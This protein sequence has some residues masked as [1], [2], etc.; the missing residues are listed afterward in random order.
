M[1]DL[2]N[3]TWTSHNLTNLLFTVI[4][5]TCPFAHA[6]FDFK[7]ISVYTFSMRIIS[8]TTSKMVPGLRRLMETATH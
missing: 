5:S 7:V 1:Y 4:V 3:T 2:S 8:L 6:R